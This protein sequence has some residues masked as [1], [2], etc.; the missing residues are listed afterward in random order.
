V[1]KKKTVKKTEVKKVEER[2][3]VPSL[4]K[5]LTKEE[6]NKLNK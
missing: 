2:F 4:G 6:I 5:S 3:F 1:A